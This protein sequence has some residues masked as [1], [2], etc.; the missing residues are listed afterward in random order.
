MT[1]LLSVR[2]VA[3]A[4]GGRIGC[5]GVNFDL[6]P[7]EVLGIVGE[8]GSGKSLTALSVMQLLPHGSKLDGSI[9]FDGQELTTLSETRMCALRGRR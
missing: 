5:T 2:D 7:G 8:S 1:P 9:A 6:Y 4:Y 3:K